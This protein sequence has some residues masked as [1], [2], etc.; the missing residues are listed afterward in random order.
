MHKAHL[1][2]SNVAAWIY[3][4]LCGTELLPLP[5][6]MIRRGKWPKII[7]RKQNHSCT[8]VSIAV[9][10]AVG[11]VISISITGARLHSFHLGRCHFLNNIPLPALHHHTHSAGKWEAGRPARRWKAL[12][13]NR[14]RFS[15]PH[16]N[17]QLRMAEEI[18][19]TLGNFR[20]TSMAT[21]GSEWIPWFLG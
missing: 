12:L 13:H 4:K 14:C 21:F 18:L 2:V 8:S 17:T 5:F 6:R 11:G 1:F 20:P 15:F 9:L 19:S 16:A 3:W 7:S 10:C